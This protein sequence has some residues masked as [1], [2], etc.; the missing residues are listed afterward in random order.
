MWYLSGKNNGFLE[1]C[2][3]YF[4]HLVQKPGEKPGTA[5]ILK[6]TQGMGE[7][8]MFEKLVEVLCGE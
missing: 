8:L 5:L 1:Y 6:G 7:N 4:A 2:L 3:N